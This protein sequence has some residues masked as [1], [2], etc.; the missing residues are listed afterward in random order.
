MSLLFLCVALC[1]V[2]R[3]LSS[4]EEENGVMETAHSTQVNVGFSDDMFYFTF[5]A[6]FKKNWSK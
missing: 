4:M 2:A 3:V 1:F 5:N 6:V